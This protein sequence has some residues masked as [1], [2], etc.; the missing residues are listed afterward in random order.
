MF[1]HLPLFFMN[2]KLCI[3]YLLALVM[4]T[5]EQGE[6]SQ[7]QSQK[8]VLSSLCYLATDLRHLASLLEIES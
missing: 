2:M 8:I 4:T 3:Q 1:L 5:K 7:I 6:K